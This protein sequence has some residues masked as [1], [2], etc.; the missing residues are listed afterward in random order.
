MK[1]NCI[2][3]GFSTCCQGQV[4][5]AVTETGQNNF[6]STKSGKMARKVFDLLT[7]LPWRRRRRSHHLFS[8]LSDQAVARCSIRITEFLFGIATVQTKSR[9]QKIWVGMVSCISSSASKGTVSGF[10]HSQKKLKTGVMN[11]S[12]ISPR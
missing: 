4:D 10:Y 2:L 3:L 12:R 8:Q 5:K 9:G 6:L 11:I 1:G 7:P